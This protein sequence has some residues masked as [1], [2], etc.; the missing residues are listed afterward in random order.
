M[1][2]DKL[3]WIELRGIGR[4]EIDMEPRVLFEKA[5]DTLGPVGQPPV[6]EKNDVTRHMT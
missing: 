1:P 5:G 6:P 3:I 4:Q 2:P